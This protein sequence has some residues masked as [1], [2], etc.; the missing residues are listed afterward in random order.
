MNC[1]N[2]LINGSNPVTSG[3]TTSQKTAILSVPQISMRTF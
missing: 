3:T 1:G 2:D